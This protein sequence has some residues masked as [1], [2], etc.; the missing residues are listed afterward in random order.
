[1]GDSN[2]QEKQPIEKIEIFSYLTNWANLNN[3]MNSLGLPESLLILNSNLQTVISPL[4][5]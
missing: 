2:N 5:K 3:M 1:M 4:V